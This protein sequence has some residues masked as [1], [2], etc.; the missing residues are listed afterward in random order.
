MDEE[1]DLL[2]QTLDFDE[3]LTRR[4]KF[5]IRKCLV[6][7]ICNSME[8]FDSI[9]RLQKLL[10]VAHRAEDKLAKRDVPSECYKQTCAQV[11]QFDP[12]ANDMIKNGAEEM[13][14]CQVNTV[15]RLA[16]VVR[17]TTMENYSPKATTMTFQWSKPGV[18]TTKI[19]SEDMRNI[20]AYIRSVQGLLQEERLAAKDAG[21]LKKLKN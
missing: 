11:M 9:N 17:S 19:D 12:K 7:E 10:S 20:V 1:V 2:D 3:T 4:Q 15:L 14:I 6:P 21:T 18:S 5:A 8:K 16:E 13:L